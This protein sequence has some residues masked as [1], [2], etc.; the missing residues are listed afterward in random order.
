L[1]DAF[2]DTP[3][4]K[5]TMTIL[6]GTR[7]GTY[8]IVEPI[9][10]GGMGEV[11][12]AIDANLKRD[13]AIKVLPESFA[14]DANRL[15]RFQR[16]AEVLASLNHPN[17]AHIYGLERSDGMAALVMEIVEGSTLAERIAQGPLP[18]DEA[19]NV[20]MQIADAL[21]A[22]HEQN[23]V[24][25]DLKPANIKLRPDGTVKVLDF[26]L[27]KAL[28][29]RTTSGAQAS[30]L[31]TPAM[32]EAGIVLGT[33][34]YMSP[35]QA[36]GK[37]VDQRADIWAFGCV[38]YEML[39][40]QPAFGG[41]DVTTTLARVLER[42]A[43]LSALPRTCTP[44]VR[45]TLKLCLEKDARKRVADI[46]DVKLA[47]AGAFEAGGGDAAAAAALRARRGWWVAAGAVLGMLAL[48][49]PALEHLRETPP[50]ETRV[51]V[52]TPATLDP[53]SF[54]LSPDGRQLAFQATGEDGRSRLWLRSLAAT[55]AE[56]LAGTEDAFAPFWSPDGRA[57]GFFVPGALRRLD[58]GGGTPQTLASLRGGGGTQGGAWAAD[59]VVVFSDFGNPLQRVAASGGEV[60]PLTTLGPGQTSHLY[61]HL[62]P[63][64]R[65]VL[66][67]VPSG[68]DAEI[69]LGELDGGAPIRLTDADSGAAYLPTGWLL[70]VR[71]G[72]LVAQR[73]D[74][75][76]AKLTGAVLTLADGVPTTPSGRGAFTVSTTGLV[77]YRAQGQ[78]GELQLTWVDRAG[79]VLGTVGDA[80]G[81]LNNPRVAPDGQGVA[82]VRRV[83]GNADLWLLD[84]VRTSRLTFDA[85][86]DIFP[87]W[88]PDGSRLVFGSS[89]AG[90]LDLYQK[91]ASG[92]GAEDALIIS[93]EFK[94]PTSLTTDGRFLL[95][96]AAGAQGSTD[97]WVLATAGNAE[98][99]PFLQTP[100]NE[101]WGEFS[102]DGRWVAYTSNESGRDEIYV[103]PFVPPGEEGTA[104]VTVGQWQV[105]TAGGY[106]PVWSPDGRELYYVN[107]EGGM[108]AV[109]VSA[110][111]TGF[112]AATPELLFATRIAGGG[113][114]QGQGR[115]Y[116]V[117]ADGRFLINMVL[118][119]AA[120]AP[121][122]LI[123]NWNPQTP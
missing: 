47:L 45:H 15:A 62:L 78:T 57:L 116:D 81:S 30:P 21:E 1:H 80:D 40:G 39:T 96:F 34:T 12:R 56:P 52:V 89:R 14:A 2:D 35:E 90:Q 95:Y 36:R 86:N 94:F 18:G 120:A 121:I 50:P 26:G 115:Q 7:L 73:L 10:A 17:I 117:A 93:D 98:P 59:D 105:S 19:L 106:V 82:V 84:N 48:A 104:A 101:R 60:S 42:G 114:S 22:A 88:S 54:A 13:V 53:T 3:R 27:A 33:A 63:D 76:E 65:H 55:S 99:T 87:V 109:A 37:H 66:F 72:T 118:D 8:T 112:A 69:Y 123:Q 70:W 5:L 79:T 102:P 110:S 32:T 51:D 28:D 46:R 103:R 108:M 11:Y 20:A 100:F 111:P 58:L 43:D 77:A 107:P 122:T 92:T 83:Q 49:L 64:G 74:L 113:V 29:M 6:S 23:I 9:G 68:T 71:A 97:L 85:S 67:Y 16:E 44:A 75:G 4:A 31:A 119:S 91:L 24:H 41:E 25:R 61:P 38:L